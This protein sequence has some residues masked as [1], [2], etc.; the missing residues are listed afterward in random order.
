MAKQK[1]WQVN[2]VT[3]EREFRGTVN[4]I[5]PFGTIEKGL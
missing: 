5:K 4:I 3:V 1:F 2:Y